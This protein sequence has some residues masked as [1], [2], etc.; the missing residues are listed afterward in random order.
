MASNK[1]KKCFLEDCSTPTA[2]PRYSVNENKRCYAL[3]NSNHL[4]VLQ[5]KV[6]GDL[7]PQNQD[8]KRCD[9]AFT[10]RSF[11]TAILVELKGRHV[12]D[13][14]DQISA[15]LNDFSRRYSYRRYYGRIVAGK[16]NTPDIKPNK[17][18]ELSDKLKSAGGSLL[19]RSVK[20]A[21]TL[22]DD[23]SL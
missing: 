19:I 12:S 14:L 10:S 17:Y 22:N 18:K 8:I 5:T 21:E 15:T 20:L 13:A 1:R 2:K 6:D 4:D 3:Q 9:Y 16:V 23:F 7:Y 11:E